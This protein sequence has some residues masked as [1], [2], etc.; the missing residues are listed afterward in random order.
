MNQKENRERARKTIIGMKAAA[1]KGQITSQP[2][3]GYLAGVRD[4][5]RRL[6]GPSMVHD[7]ERKIFMQ[8]AFTLMATGNYSKSEVVEILNAAGFRTKQGKKYSPQS[9]GSQLKNIKYAGFQEVEGEIV[10]GDW[11]PLIDEETFRRVQKLVGGKH[12]TSVPRNKRNPDFPLRAFVKCTHCGHK[13]SG[14]WPRGSK[15]TRYP[16]YRCRKKGCSGFNIRK[17]ELE[18][19]F[20]GFLEGLAIDPQLSTLFHEILA[21]VWKERQ[22]GQ[23]DLKTSIRKE[24]SKLE[25]KKRGLL[26]KFISSDALPEEVYREHNNFLDNEIQEAKSRLM[27]L[28]PVASDLEKAIGS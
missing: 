4:G 10:R 17:E 15:G 26:D 6:Y 19:Q 16:Y 22:S 18:K 9:F 2:P 20:V 1:L 23:E 3:L 27:C 25:E 7:P 21:D 28:E 8:W 14:S 13:I 24:I 11:E 12:F 5:K